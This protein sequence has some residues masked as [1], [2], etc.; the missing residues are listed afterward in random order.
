MNL[1]RKKF[2]PIQTHPKKSKNRNRIKSYSQIRKAN[3]QLLIENKNDKDIYQNIDIED[4]IQTKSM[5]NTNSDE[6]LY[7]EQK[8]YD[9]ESSKNMKNISN[10]KDNT[11]SMNESSSINKISGKI[12]NN[13][14]IDEL[15]KYKK[16]NDND[17]IIMKS[18]SYKDKGSSIY[19]KSY[20]YLNKSSSNK[21]GNNNTNSFNTKKYNEQ[22]SKSNITDSVFNNNDINYINNNNNK[23]G[24]IY[25]YNR[26]DNIIKNNSKKRDKKHP[27]VYKS[28]SFSKYFNLIK[29]GKNNNI[30]NTNI[31]NIN[32]D[33]TSTNDFTKLKSKYLEL[34]N[35]HDLTLSKL[36]KEKKK[37]KTQEKEI[38]I[39]INSIRSIKTGEKKEN[40]IEEMKELIDKLKEENS[41]FRQE[42]ILSQALINSLKSEL[43][44]TKNIKLNT[45]EDISI[46]DKNS[47][48]N[49]DN[50][51][52][53]NNKSKNDFI[54]EINELNYA[55]NKKN[56]I[57]ESVLIENKKL[58]HKLKY[59]NS[60]NTSKEK[61]K[62]RNSNNKISDILYDEAMNIINK[63]NKYRNS[64]M[65]D[66]N[67][68]ILTEN[69]FNELE[70][71][72]NEIDN[73]NNINNTEQLVE[74]YISL[75]KLISNEFDKLL[76]Y[77]NNYWKEKYMNKYGIKDNNNNLNIK[78]DF[79]FD[80]I[81]HNL[82]DLCL[83][84]SSYL[85]GSPKDLLLEGINLIKNLENLYKEK[86]RKK[87]N[88][89][90]YD[91]NINDLIMRQERQLENIKRKL[92]YNQY[93]QSNNYHYFS[94]SNSS[95]NIKNALG[96]TYMTNYFNN[97]N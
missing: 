92:T 88:N 10:L 57:L 59:N 35:A 29:N 77:N 17:N 19:N 22:N 16:Y 86:N 82:M 30:N 79:I 96:L 43:K 23:K 53:P 1:F 39:M 65:D 11:S 97:N 24:L 91:D 47:N 21:S 44:N 78:S 72:K 55:L 83:L 84:S 15:M 94:N 93:N 7:L 87:S 68:L 5:K 76:L 66:F 3:S 67:N 18:N 54:K 46:S 45:I 62:N 36:K 81:K 51:N 12:R 95:S 56:E 37:N 20:S 64:N 41:N 71:L 26:M 6:A 90:N 74:Y 2:I 14:N 32:N 28:Q 61:N 8:N 48:Y 60:N 75:I 80:K 63:Y 34:K 50:F 27:K 52:K 31:N 58:R 9:I 38:E 85:K 49:Y 13:Y 69:F 40:N 33:S 70:K 89:D 4:T 73:A 25:N 42:L